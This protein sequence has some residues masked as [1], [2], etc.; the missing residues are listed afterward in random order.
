MQA[1]ASELWGPGFHH[2]PRLLVL[3]H[4]SELSTYFYL[5]AVCLDFY[6]LMFF[7]PASEYNSLF[8]ADRK[9]FSSEACVSVHAYREWR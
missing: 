8:Y 2:F 9:V 3:L 7:T 5:T 6:I 1:V 4:V